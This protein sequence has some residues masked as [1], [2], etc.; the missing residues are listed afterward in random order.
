MANKKQQD[1]A[2]KISVLEN[3]VYFFIE[4][5]IIIDYGNR[6][7]LLVIQK[8]RLLADSYYRTVRGA[9]VAFVKMFG[10]KHFNPGIQCF[11]THF[12]NPEQSFLHEKIETANPVL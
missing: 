6:Y 7:R 10:K 5:V 9:R 3:S 2:V 8:G 11:W 4:N 1:S 12:Y